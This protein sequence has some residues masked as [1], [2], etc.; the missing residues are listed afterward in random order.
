[1]TA[2]GG[3]GK[4]G[5]HVDALRCV[6]AAPPAADGDTVQIGRSESRRSDT[7]AEAVLENLTAA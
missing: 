4:Q 6:R 5:A 7:A 3:G 2:K 1:M